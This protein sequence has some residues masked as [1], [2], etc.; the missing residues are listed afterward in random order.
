MWWLTFAMLIG[1]LRISLIFMVKTHTRNE[2][3][4]QRC[5]VFFF[6]M[7]F[8]C[9]RFSF[10]SFKWKCKFF[11]LSCV[12]CL[13]NKNNKKKKVK[14]KKHLKEDKNNIKMCNGSSYNYKKHLATVLIMCSL[15]LF[16]LFLIH[17]C[18]KVFFFC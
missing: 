3:Q 11:F 8:F 4:A 7:L 5:F 12:T 2:K 13:V 9:C 16:F 18:L 1:N 17:I 15:D 10:I 6:R 14:H